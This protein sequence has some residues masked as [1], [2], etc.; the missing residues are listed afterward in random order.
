MQIWKNPLRLPLRAATSPKGRGKPCRGER[1]ERRLWREERPERVAAVDKIK[2]KRKPE[3][4]I[5]HRNRRTL[6]VRYTH[7]GAFIC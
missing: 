1:G 5:G 4:F 2:E 6:F 7:K 3:D